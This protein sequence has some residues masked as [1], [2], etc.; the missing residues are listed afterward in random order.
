MIAESASL[1]GEIGPRYSIRHQWLFSAKNI[2]NESWKQACIAEVYLGG[3]IKK[4]IYSP[5]E[6]PSGKTNFK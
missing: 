5:F 3:S 6:V 1:F 2:M 4:Y